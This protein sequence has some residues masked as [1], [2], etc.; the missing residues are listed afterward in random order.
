MKL[1]DQKW[2][3]AH[4]DGKSHVTVTLMSTHAPVDEVADYAE[5]LGWRVQAVWQSDEQSSMSVPSV[6]VTH[7]L[8]RYVAP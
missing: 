6:S 7:I 3:D 1:L 8:F 4:D 2:G 5:K